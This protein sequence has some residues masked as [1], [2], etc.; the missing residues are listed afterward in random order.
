[1]D[2]DKVAF[3]GSTEVG[4][5]IME[6]AAETNLKRV[7]LEL[8]GKSPNIVFADADMDAAIEGAHFAPVL[9][10][11]PVLLR[12]LSACSSKRKSYDEFVERA[13]RA[14]RPA[15]SAIRFD[16]KTEQ[17]PQVDED[18]FDKVMGYI[19]S[20][21][22]EGAK[23]LCGGD[24]VGDRGYFVAPT[25]FADVKDNMKIAQEEIFGPVM[26]ILKFRDMDDLVDRANAQHVW[27]GRRCL[28]PGHY[29]GPRTWL[30]TFVR[31]PFGSTATTSSTPPL[32]LADSSN[33]ASGAN[34]ASTAFS[35]TPRSRP[36]PS[37]CKSSSRRM[38][39]YRTLARC[40]SC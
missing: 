7:T 38:E 27:L 10:S 29:Q 20:G 26:S 34:W 13:S 25:I 4:Q 15:R 3:T 21:K 18:Q 5:L 35:S 12:R 39:P 24:R 6:A 31:V 2:V 9:Q 30:I 19:E 1:M 23:M 36:L 8:G 28:D 33:P 14:P 16:P 40:G 22:R 11:G 17:G 32:P 37:S